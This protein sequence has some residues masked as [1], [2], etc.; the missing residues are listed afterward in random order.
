MQ[1]IL[2][3]RSELGDDPQ[4]LRTCWKVAKE[5]PRTWCRTRDPEVSVSEIQSCMAY[6]TGG[7]TTQE[8]LTWG[9]AR[10]LSLSPSRAQFLQANFVLL[11]H[12]Q[13]RIS[14]R[15]ISFSPRAHTQWLNSRKET[16][17]FANGCVTSV[18]EDI[19]LFFCRVASTEYFKGASQ[20]P[21]KKCL[22]CTLVVH[23]FAVQWMW[24]STITSG[25]IAIRVSYYFLDLWYS[26]YR[27][28]ETGQQ[29]TE[30]G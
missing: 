3:K 16:S 10:T 17:F 15:P 29:W 22:S 20:Y 4:R 6:V 21:E 11:A 1:N 14:W 9:E 7:I 26:A 23:C 28:V 18:Q 19:L 24:V 12:M 27:Y 2:A 13:W 8:T 25:R 30:M 5:L